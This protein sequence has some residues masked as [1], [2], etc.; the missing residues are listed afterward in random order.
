MD[1]LFSA[2]YQGTQLARSKYGTTENIKCVT[3]F[4]TVRLYFMLLCSYREIVQPLYSVVM[5]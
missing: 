5:Y 4:V 1:Y 2:A 3:S